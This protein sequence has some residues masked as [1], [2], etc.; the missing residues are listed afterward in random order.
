MFDIFRSLLSLTKDF[1]KKRRHFTHEEWVGSEK[2]QGIIDK[3]KKSN[4]KYMEA[5][6]LKIIW[7]YPPNNSLKIKDEI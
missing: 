6:G 7:E 5:S 2:K 1:F 4:G 3:V